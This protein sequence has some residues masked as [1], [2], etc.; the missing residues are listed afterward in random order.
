MDVTDSLQALETLA[1]GTTSLAAASLLLTC[2]C[3]TCSSC[4]MLQFCCY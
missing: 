2:T 1:Q 4:N 3:R